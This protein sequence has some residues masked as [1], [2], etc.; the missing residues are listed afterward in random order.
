MSGEGGVGGM[1]GRRIW[2]ILA[3]ESE[4]SIGGVGLGKKRSVEK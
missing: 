4:E 2:V 1:Q 3:T